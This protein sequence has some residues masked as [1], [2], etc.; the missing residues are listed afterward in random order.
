MT[1]DDK[2]TKRELKNLRE[3]AVKRKADG[4]IDENRDKLTKSGSGERD[5]ALA[6]RSTGLGSRR[7]DD[8]AEVRGQLTGFEANTTPWGRMTQTQYQRK[9]DQVG[10]DHENLISGKIDRAIWFGSEPLPDK[11]LG[12][13]LAEAIRRAG[14]EYFHVPW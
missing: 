11:G 8:L 12:G 6:V 10:A 1:A 14:I 7:Y 13:Q 3:Y 2:W 5:L 4:V 9:M